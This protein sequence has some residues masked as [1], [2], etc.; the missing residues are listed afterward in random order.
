MIKL[1]VPTRNR[2]SSVNALL[3]YLETFYPNTQLIIADGSDE[4][5][6]E[7]VEKVCGN[8]SENL[9]VEFKSYPSDL[10]YFER[11]LDVLLSC[12]DEFI[13]MGADDDYPI[14][15]V[16]DK[17]KETL[18]NNAQ[19]KSIVPADVVLTLREDGQLTSRLSHSR[20]V[21]HKNPINRVKDYSY[22]HFATS[23]GVT[24]KALLLERYRMMSEYNCASFIDFQ[25]GIEDTMH[26]EIKAVP[27]IGCIRTQT[28]EHEYFRAT[29]TMVFLRKSEKILAYR[30]YLTSKLGKLE[31]NAETDSRKLA[32]LL[33]SRRIADL[34]GGGAP[35][36]S[37]FRDSKQFKDP[38]LQQ[39]YKNFYE[40][41]EDGT[42]IRQN[43]IA[44][45]RYA[46]DVLLSNVAKSESTGLVKNYENI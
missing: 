13:A 9:S 29:D 23:Y 44:K 42:E 17:A 35:G 37:N 28:F 26:G 20:N 25:I 45:L 39:Q 4:L 8:Y 24:Q 21:L 3:G 19:Y 14:M 36:K 18:I 5:R 12:D 15:E 6:K 1:L 40:L 38:T 34:T 16:L 11:I 32:D 22:W 10:P 46:R 31:E 7:E 41:F 30:D 27:E 2:P 33:I 43:Y